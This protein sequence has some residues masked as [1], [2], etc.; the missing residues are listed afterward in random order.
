MAGNFRD[1]SFATK[2]SMATNLEPSGLWI[3]TRGTAGSCPKCLCSN[4]GMA[5]Q[6][7]RSASYGTP[8][9]E[10]RSHE[11]GISAHRLRL[12][13]AKL[14]HIRLLQTRQQRVT[15]FS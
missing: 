13:E 15:F 11:P 7:L 9:H 12:F 2:Y 14:R 1:N 3:Q 4:D 5:L 8:A 10:C 6:A